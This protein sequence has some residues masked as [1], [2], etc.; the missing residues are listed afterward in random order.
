MDQPK[1]G[2]IKAPHPDVSG[3]DVV[4]GKPANYRNVGAST[5][6]ICQEC[7]DKMADD[8]EL[9]DEFLK[10]VGYYTG[11]EKREQMQALT[12]H[13]EESGGYAVEIVEPT[14]EEARRYLDNLVSMPGS[15]GHLETALNN[16]LTDE[17]PLGI[18]HEIEFGTSESV[19]QGTIK[20]MVLEG[21]KH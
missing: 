6:H 7:F 15:R 14:P 4:C 18:T 12:R 9:Q 2:M 13:T 3:P 16:L 11:P 21:R 19:P 1:C 20:I 17:L 5:H 10:I 8:P